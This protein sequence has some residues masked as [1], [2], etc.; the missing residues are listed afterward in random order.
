VP[1]FISL[2][3]QVYEQDQPLK[4]K[5]DL[6]ERYIDRQLSFDLRVADRRKEVQ[7]KDWA[8]KTVEQETNWRE[9]KHSLIW[10]AQQ[11]KQQNQVEISVE[12]LQPFCL[13]NKNEQ[14]TYWVILFMSNV[15]PTGTIATII[16]F[17]L[18]HASV[19][20]SEYNGLIFS[21][22]LLGIP[23]SFV[24]STESKADSARMILCPFIYLACFMFKKRVPNYIE[25]HTPILHEIHLKSRNVI[26]IPSR[27]ELKGLLIGGFYYSISASEMAWVP[28]GMFLFAGHSFLIDLSET[29]KMNRFHGILL[30]SWHVVNLRI[31]EESLKYEDS[32]YEHHAFAFVVTSSYLEIFVAQNRNRL[33]KIV[34]LLMSLPFAIMLFTLLVST[35]IVSSFFSEEISPYSPVAQGRQEKV[36]TLFLLLTISVIYLIFQPAS[37]S[38]FQQ[39][40]FSFVLGFS[41]CGIIC[42]SLNKHLALRITLRLFNILPWNLARFLTYCHERRLLQQIG[43]RYRF[44]HRELLDHFAKMEN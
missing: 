43:G 7:K 36:K 23:F 28:L 20:I 39:E 17:R 30:D 14:W 40:I 5:A 26:R 32:A 16:V 19:N 9:V 33:I 2:A 27:K 10:V 35:S 15:I 1:L 44:I 13:T 6:F 38:K 37:L 31:E 18:A 34:F 4:G 24:A 3:A 29:L 8:F 41:L 25:L 42:L 12:D 22:F 21:V 11:L